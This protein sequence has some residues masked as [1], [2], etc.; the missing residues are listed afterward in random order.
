VLI[1]IHD[2]GKIITI[3]GTV[4]RSGAI[5]M[6]ES[7]REYECGRCSHRF[8]M[9]SDIEQ[10]G[11]IQLPTRCPSQPQQG[12]K[13]CKSTVFNYVE[14]SRVCRDYQE[15]KI[16]EQISKLSIG[17]IPRQA[18]VVLQDDLVD[19]CQAGDDVWITGRIP[20]NNHYFITS[21]THPLI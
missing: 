3:P 17:S 19:N 15:I 13:P 8:L 2:Q 9:H 20:L 21:I 11:L 10:R 4:I 18:L 14:S 7:Q 5:K 1:I 12:R 16:Q 6:L